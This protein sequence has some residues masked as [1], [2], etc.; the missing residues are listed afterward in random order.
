MKK[1]KL[2]VSDLRVETF[3]SGDA[4]V[5]GGTVRANGSYPHRTCASACDDPATDY[6]DHSCEGAIGVCMPFSGTDC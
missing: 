4:G 2:D 6:A 3:E 1:L 5:S